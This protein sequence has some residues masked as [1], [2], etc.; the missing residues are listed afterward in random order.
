MIDVTEILVHWHAGRSL[1]E[2]SQ[3]LGV[4]RKTIRKYIAPAMAAG[5]RPG[6]PAKGEGEWQ[7]LVREWFPEL[8]DTRL[9]QV[10]WPAIAV[11]HEF[12]RGQLE[13]GVTV[14][15]IHQRLRDERGL[16]VSVASLRRYVA[17]NVPEEVRRAQVRVLNPYPAVPGEQARHVFRPPSAARCL[18]AGIPRRGH[19]RDVDGAAQVGRPMRGSGQAVLLPCQRQDRERAAGRGAVAL[20]LRLVSDRHRE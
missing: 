3:S 12:I 11:H 6:G 16:A 1:N 7:E 13:A 9:R 8:S 10:T 5:I 15:T 20:T 18:W 4:Y 17:A 14:S 2:M 19:V